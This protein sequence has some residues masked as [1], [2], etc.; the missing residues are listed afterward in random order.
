MTPS[1]HTVPANA[2]DGHQMSMPTGVF[3]VIETGR[4]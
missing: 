1:A 3:P 4:F 2:E